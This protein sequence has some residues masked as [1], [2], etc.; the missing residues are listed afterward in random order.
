[1]GHISC[2]FLRN[3]RDLTEGDDP[4]ETDIQFKLLLPMSLHARV[5]AAAKRDGVSLSEFI[6]RRLETATLEYAEDARKVGDVVA[7]IAE[8]TRYRKSARGFATFRNAVG[9]VLKELAPRNE[10]EPD[11]EIERDGYK[12]ALAALLRYGLAE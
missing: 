4:V 6:R 1:M 5:T 11:Q 3:G 2:P 12:V 10:P 7:H 9:E 8:K